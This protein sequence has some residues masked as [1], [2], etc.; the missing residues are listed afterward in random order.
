MKKC[1]LLLP[2]I[3]IMAFLYYPG[4]ATGQ[5]IRLKILGQTDFLSGGTAGLRIIALDEQGHKTLEGVKISINFVSD[6][7]KKELFSGITDSS[8]SVN[9]SFKIPSDF[10]GKAKL[11]VI[12]SRETAKKE[13]AFD[14]NITKSYQLLLTTDKPLYQ[15]GQ[16]INLRLLALKR[17]DMEPVSD[18]PVIFEIQDAKGNKV[19][20]YEGKLSEFGVASGKFNLADEV[21]M[22]EYHIKAIVEKEEIEKNVTVKRYVLPKF[23]NTVKSDK[24]Y[25]QPGQT[26]KGTVES[27][28]FFGKPVSDGDVNITFSTFDVQENKL[29]EISGKTDKEGFYVFEYKVPDYFTGLPLEGGKAALDMKITV[30]DRAKHQEIIYKSLPVVKDPVQITVVPESNS[31]IP[32]VENVVY[33]LTNYPDGSPA[34][35]TLDITIDGKTEKIKTDDTGFAEVYVKP[36]H[37]KTSYEIKCY[38]DRGNSASSKGVFQS[39]AGEQI[40]LRTDKALY[41]VG[42]AIKLNVF[43]VTGEVTAYVDIIRDNQTIL[44]KAI[45]I[46]SGKGNLE[47]SLTP[48]CA[49]SLTLH[50]YRITP[51][52]Q[53]IRDTRKIVVS[54]ANDLDIN[55]SMNKGVYLPGEDGEIKFKVADKSGKPV[56]SV[57]GVDIVDESL[58]AL[59]DRKPGFEKLYFLLEAELLEPKYEIHGIEFSDL[60]RGFEEGKDKGDT[61]RLSKIILK[62]A[63]S[64]EVFTVNKDSFVEDLKNLYT[65]FTAVYNGINLFYGANNRY[66][67]S[68]SEMIKGKY[69]LKDRYLKE[70]EILDPWGN[71]IYISGGGTTGYVE[72]ISFGPDG[73][74]G[75]DDD[76]SYQNIYQILERYISYNDPFWSNARWFANEEGGAM[77]VM[78]AENFAGGPPVLCPMAALP[79]DGPTG[80]SAPE[81]PA[82]V[83]EYFPETLYTNP[84]VITDEKGVAKINVKMA[85]SITTWRLTSFAS[86]LKGDMGNHQSGI[87][88]F[89]DF[90]ADIDLPVF[91]TQDDEI[92]IPVAVYNYLPDKQTVK[93]ELLKD[94]WFTLLDDSVKNISLEKDQVSV[95]YFRIKAKD[96]G[97]HPLTVYAKGSKMSDAIKRT[98]QIEPKGKLFIETQ[99]DRLTGSLSKT[100][101]IPDNAIRGAS[102][103]LVTL[104][105]GLFSQV[106]EGLDKILRMPG[107]CFEQTSS[108]TYPNVLVLD[109]LKRVNKI[110]PEIQ[111][112]AETYINN[113]YQRLLTFEVK[114]GGFSWFGDAPANKLLT[115]FGIMEFKDMAK[116]HSVDPALIK[117]TQDWLAAQQLQDGS[118]KPDESYCHAESWSRLQNSNLLVTAYITWALLDTGYENKGITDKAVSYIKEHYTQ[119]KDPYM[120]SIIANALS[121]YD[122]SD[123]ILK[124][125]FQTLIDMKKEDKSSVYWESSLESI[126]FSSGISSTI[127]TTA[128]AT[129]AMLKSDLYPDVVNKCITFLI[130]NK[131]AYGTWHSTQPTILTL[132]TLLLAAE[133]ATEE[134]NVAG[135]IL[136]NGKKFKDFNIT[137]KNFDVYQQFDLGTVAGKNNVDIKFE[138]KGNCLYQIVTKYYLPWTVIK[139]EKTAESLSIKVSYDRTKLVRND[140][141]TCKAQI[142]NN[143]KGDIKMTIIDLGIPPGFTVETDGLEKLVTDKVIQ[144]YSLTGRQVI[145]YIDEIKGEKSL[146]VSYQ[147]R[148]KYPVKVQAPRSQVYEY[149]KP[150][151]VT[152]TKPV[153]MV[154]E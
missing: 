12:A 88:V 2:V 129:Y 63:P 22:G 19:F 127:E 133:K 20:K 118:W 73:K 117:R 24:D 34:R 69:L 11:S 56:Q 74:K 101:E 143:T 32:S 41:R 76:I 103:I 128:L 64:D 13:I 112:K 67:S 80:G 131:D 35:T 72:L 43:S 37:E 124:N 148:A 121:S 105:P 10:S 100:I 1:L 60:V 31:F 144:K 132:R 95:V 92:S 134:V 136:I 4:E 109:Y 135:S 115:A 145:I 52:G 25:Y 147:L 28:Y 138:G 151:N 78:K 120:L 91:L 65:N 116:V 122:K 57:L 49:G 47:W 50:A 61:Q 130:Q 21:N 89:Q 18:M 111:M 93:L 5:H 146:E 45:D 81:A 79:S 70:E 104:Y 40:L 140:L 53:I 59:A 48:D 39:A 141:V 153:E 113:G 8:G 90:F 107:G 29:S 137:S 44:T 9:S 26:V 87:K 62:N 55:V 82:R 99:S 119:A 16:T 123:P 75:T 84:E 7:D 38:D 83:R 23:N 106:V 36:E 14:V 142:T 51:D 68:V 58:F 110:T 54:S 94:N 3:L 15:P 96:V 30:T 152:V 126:T 86:S 102:K 98:I 46:K 150:E 97:T 42:E 114:G 77:E 149:Y 66:P 108:T 85:D 154:V 125:V 139:E 17:P 71:Y 6:K 33:I 27:R